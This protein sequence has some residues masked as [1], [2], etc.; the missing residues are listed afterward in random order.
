MFYSSET[1]FPVLLEN[2]PLIY[3]KIKSTITYILSDHSG[4]LRFPRTADDWYRLSH[5]QRGRAGRPVHRSGWG[6]RCGRHG[7]HPLGTQVPQR[8]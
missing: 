7:R 5:T 1:L 2:C 3:R 6:R 8:E 4:E